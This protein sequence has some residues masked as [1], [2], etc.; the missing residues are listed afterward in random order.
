MLGSEGLLGPAWL[1]WQRVP[2]AAGSARCLL[3]PAAR[4]GAEQEQH[5][6]HPQP[7][8]VSSELRSP[9]GTAGSRVAAIRAGFC[10]GSEDVPGTGCPLWLLLQEAELTAGIRCGALEKQRLWWLPV[11]A[12]AT[13]P[14]GGAASTH[15]N[16]FF[17]SSLPESGH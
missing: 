3:Q 6:S 13:T 15:A 4:P 11:P 10:L 7:W 12:A 2:A 17:G 16:N 5:R 1:S 8:L 9:L 14:T